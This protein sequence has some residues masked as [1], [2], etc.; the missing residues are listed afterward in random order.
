MAVPIQIDHVT[1]GLSRL[2]TQW[3]DKPVVV[4][5]LKSY[6]EQINAVEDTLFQMLEE[7][8]IYEA[9]G[10]QLDVLGALFGVDRL[11]RDDGDYR[12]AILLRIAQLQDDGTTE[13]F[14]ATLRNISNSD[15]VDFWEHD[16]GDVHAYL[17]GG[18]TSKTYSQV[19]NAVPAGVNIRIIFDEGGDSFIPA[20]LIPNTADIQVFD[21]VQISDLQVDDG[22]TTS[23]LQAQTFLSDTDMRGY[24]PELED[25]EIINPLADL[26]TRD[27]FSYTGNIVFENGDLMVDE[28]GIPLLWTDYEFI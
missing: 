9:I 8:G 2:I 23:D 28:N 4:G 15:L 25:T 7:R 24:L 20:E 18:V 13:V 11:G 12:S 21:G 6:M 16:S 3:Q 26:I 22:V 5:L 1:Q 27:S 14:M 19:E 10:V 17:G